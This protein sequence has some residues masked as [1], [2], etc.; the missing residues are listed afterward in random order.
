MFLKCTYCKQTGCFSLSLWSVPEAGFVK[1][2]KLLAR[3]GQW[4]VLSENT[5]VIDGQSVC[6]L[7]KN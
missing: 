6:L 4:R 3:F 5:V 7:Q 2:P 1:T